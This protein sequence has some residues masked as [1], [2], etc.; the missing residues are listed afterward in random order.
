MQVEDVR[1]ALQTNTHIVNI[2]TGFEGWGNGCGTEP[3][4]L[5]LNCSNYAGG[6]LCKTTVTRQFG[7]WALKELRCLSFNMSLIEKWAGI[8]GEK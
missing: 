3:Q 1:C 5:V 2:T 7:K 6:P 4:N 8:H